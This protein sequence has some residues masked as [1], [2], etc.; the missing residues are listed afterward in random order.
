MWPFKKEKIEYW[1]ATEVALGA[2]F[3]AAVIASLFLSYG[4]NVV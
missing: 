3:I 1:D 2:I 4:I